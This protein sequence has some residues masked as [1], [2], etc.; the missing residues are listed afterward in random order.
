LRRARE[1]VASVGDHFV[2]V[3]VELSAA[4]GHLDVQREH[5][6]MLSSEDLTADL[7]NQ[8]AHTGDGDHAVRRMETA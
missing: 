8:L 7:N 4:A 3:H 5:F 1:L 2:H 6:V